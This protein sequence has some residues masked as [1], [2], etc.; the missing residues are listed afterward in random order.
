MSKI[1][2]A[3]SRTEYFSATEPVG[4]VKKRDT[5]PS[6]PD[7]VIAETESW[8]DTLYKRFPSTHVIG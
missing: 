6:I 5:V 1:N 2:M 3:D 7:N 8:F 4:N